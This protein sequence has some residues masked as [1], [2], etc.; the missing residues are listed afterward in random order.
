M[1]PAADKSPAPG[2]VE[3]FETNDFARLLG[4][5]ITDARDGYARVEMDCTGK[6]NPHG[7]AH[8]GAVF[9]LADHA[10]GIASNCGPVQYTAISVHIQYLAPARGR[11]AAVAERTAK[12]ETCDI[13]T[14]TVIDGSGRTVALFYGTAFRVLP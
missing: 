7:A 6:L 12:N 14:V 13:F 9:S 10:F 11:I 1:N 4:M 3:L 5:H 2:P 8:G